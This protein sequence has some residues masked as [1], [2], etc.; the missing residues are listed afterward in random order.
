M[1][2]SKK[3]SH[4]MHIFISSDKMPNLYWRQLYSKWL[5]IINTLSTVEL[6]SQ[7]QQE[8]TGIKPT[9]TE[10]NQLRVLQSTPFTRYNDIYLALITQESKKT[11]DF[12]DSVE[13]IFKVN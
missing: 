2:T 8:P 7:N 12:L 11:L 10:K 6:K 3:N 4:Q 1:T 5:D 9:P 13:I